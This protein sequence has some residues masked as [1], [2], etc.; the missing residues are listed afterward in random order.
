MSQAENSP[1]TL[2]EAAASG[3]PAICMNQGGMPEIVAH[4]RTGFVIDDFDDFCK[5]IEMF[6][7]P[8]QRKEF[9]QNSRE[10]ALDRFSVNSVL[11]KYEQ[12]YSEMKTVNQ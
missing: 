3:V 7:D 2:I 4:E 5:H 8:N 11:E 9:S 1:L 12:L 6:F 10:L